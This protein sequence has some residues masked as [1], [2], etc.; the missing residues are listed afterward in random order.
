MRHAPFAIGQAER[1]AWFK[2]MSDAVTESD[3]ID[4]AKEMMLRYFDHAAT[5]MINS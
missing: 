4:E 5:A 3:A 1:D 2:H